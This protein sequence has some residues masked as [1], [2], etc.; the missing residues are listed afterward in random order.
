MTTKLHEFTRRELLAGLPGAAGALTLGSSILAASGTA[1]A[2]EAVSLSAVSAP[3]AGSGWKAPKP[4][5]PAH[6]PLGRGIG[7]C[8]GRVAW[9][10]D[11]RAVSWAGDGWWWNPENFSGPVIEEML[12]RVLVGLA[13]LDAG[14]PVRGAWE[15]L[16]TAHNA[17]HGRSGGYRKGERI[18]VKINMNGAGGYGD[19]P[20]GHTEESYG[21]AR[22]VRALVLSL[23]EA[24]VAPANITLYDAGRIFPRWF[25][26]LV[27]EG[28]AAGVV[29]RHRRPGAPDDAVA[30]RSHPIDWAGRIRGDRSYLPK[31]VTEA[32]YLINL[33]NLKG[34]SYGMT[35][36]A[37]N[38]FGSFVN[39]DRLRAPQA[40]GLHGNV[41]GARAG[42]YSVLTDLSARA[43]LGGKTVLCLLDGLL[44]ATGEIVSTTREAALWTMPPFAGGFMASLFASQDPV[45]IDSVGADFL[46]AEPNMLER[47]YTLR[48]SPGME[49]YLHE[50]ALAD[51]APSGT[52]YT[53]GAGNR[54]GSLGVHEHWLDPVSKSYSRN[55]G[56]SEGIELVR[57]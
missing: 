22:L 20:D 55:R 44:T 46:T 37:K 11:P 41:A 19:D 54:V 32:D 10:H 50:S 23:M 30:D 48:S 25:M 5:L 45:S 9:V 26:A 47:N 27:S 16:F 2:G 15:R 28:A 1:G 3:A 7:V 43:H 6:P 56:E 4:I 35:L 8:P 53:D 40:A 31:C 38:H 52:A 34:H 33:A 12:G 17:R 13:G 24:G 29:F 39:S 14:S 21:N 36:C 51:R 49:N 57:V 42:N 18:A